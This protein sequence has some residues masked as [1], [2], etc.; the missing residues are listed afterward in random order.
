MKKV[1][2]GIFWIEQKREIYGDDSYYT[3]GTLWKIEESEGKA[4]EEVE[5]MDLNETDLVVIL[6]LYSL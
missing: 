6:P 1:R 3:L 4:K 5:K 2:F